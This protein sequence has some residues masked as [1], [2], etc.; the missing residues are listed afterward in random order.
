MYVADIGVGQ[1]LGDQRRAEGGGEEVQD[2][3][4]QLLDRVTSHGR[5]ADVV[6]RDVGLVD[7]LAVALHSAV[8]GFRIE[9][10]VKVCRVLTALCVRSQFAVEVCASST[11]MGVLDDVLDRPKAACSPLT[12]HMLGVLQALVKLPASAQLLVLQYREIV[13]NVLGLLRGEMS[14]GVD[15][16]AGCVLKGLL[17][18]DADAWALLKELR[19][20]D[21]CLQYMMSDRQPAAGVCELLELLS[22]GSSNSPGG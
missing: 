18:V 7:D 2:L 3:A 13:K 15:Q 4:V 6:G 11:L 22:T 21:K 5:A 16:S 8:Q 17:M 12:R 10:V 9:Q 20:V 1:Y 14:P 19:A